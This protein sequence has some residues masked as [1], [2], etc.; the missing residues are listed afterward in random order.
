M[1]LHAPVQDLFLFSLKGQPKTSEL[2]GAHSLR[3]YNLS[4]EVPHVSIF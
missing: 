2:Q 1:V 4:S 3:L